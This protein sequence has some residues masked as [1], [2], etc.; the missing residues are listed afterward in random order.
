MSNS[1]SITLK[2]YQLK[3]LVSW[4][5]LPLHGKEA[6]ARNRF[7]RIA[8]QRMDELE[9]ERIETLSALSEK[10]EKGSPKMNGNQYDLTPEN[11]KTFQDRMG[12]LN[13]EDFVIDVLPSNRQELKSVKEIL[14]EE[15]GNR[16]FSV[17]EGRVYDEILTVFEKL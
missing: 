3:L 4:L 5:D 12:V 16:S 11:L 6:R 14:V 8:A 7:L 2:N 10:D 1:E 17:L 9:G 13:D 15:V